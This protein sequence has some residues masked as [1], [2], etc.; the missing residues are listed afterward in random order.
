MVK[1]SW[2]F[3]EW[4]EKIERKDVKRLVV[5]EEVIVGDDVVGNMGTLT[6]VDI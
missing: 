3:I 4:T 6:K 5:N 2:P 1:T